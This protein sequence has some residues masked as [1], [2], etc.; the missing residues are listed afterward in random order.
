MNYNNKKFRTV[1][2]SENGETNKETIFE[3]RQKGNILTSEYRGGHIVEGHLIGLVDPAGNIN[4]SY[5]Q[6]NGK[7]E[8][9]TG[10][11]HSRPEVLS[12]GKI[13]LHEKWQWTSGNNSTGKSVIEEI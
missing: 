11:C 13:R 3:Y 1:V 7:G 8:L 2:N 4:M 5:H 9:I 10:V 6:I 12:N